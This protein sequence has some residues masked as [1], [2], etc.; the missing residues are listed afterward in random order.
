M[1][2]S[3]KLIGAMLICT[4]GLYGCS[5]TETT[6]KLADAMSSMKPPAFKDGAELSAGLAVQNMSAEAQILGY[7]TKILTSPTMALNGENSTEYKALLSIPENQSV[8]AVLLVG[9][10]D[11]G[12]NNPD[13]LSSATTRNSFDDMVTVIE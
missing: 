7:G 2:K 9:K 4:L 1:K 10:A 8:A 12:E 13:A 6:Q 11:S 5:G 3:I